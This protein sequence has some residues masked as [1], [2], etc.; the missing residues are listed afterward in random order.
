[1]GKLTEQSTNKNTQR[2]ETLENLKKYI[3]TFTDFSEESWSIFMGCTTELNLQK[4]E[5]LLNEGEICK[6]IFYI[7]SGFCKSFY[8]QQGKDI[9]TAFYFENEFATNIKSLTKDTKSE[10]S[11]QA[12]EKL[13]V[14]SFDKIK[15]LEAY[16]K[17][18]QIETCGR[19]ILELVIAQQE[20]HSDSFKLLSPKQR[21][22]NLIL[23]NPA[24]LQRVSLTQ[25]A[26]YLGISRET[27]SRFR[28]IK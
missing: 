6:S 4:G 19:K 18:Q 25:T 12:C 3:R 14:L 28:A 13:H 16:Q 23:I 21:F 1:L 5:N 22:E 26:S 8:N 7:V 15:L 9:N 27:L 20:E 17:S 24:F 11:I 10:Y 2:L